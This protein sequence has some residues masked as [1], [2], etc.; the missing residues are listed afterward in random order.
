MSKLKQILKE[1]KNSTKIK[2]NKNTIENNPVK[3][4]ENIN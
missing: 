4:K 2:E 1:D 3:I